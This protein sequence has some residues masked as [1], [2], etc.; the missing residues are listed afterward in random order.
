MLIVDA[1][2]YC[3]DARSMESLRILDE[4]RAQI[5]TFCATLFTIPGRC[6]VAFIEWV[7]ETRTWL[8]LVPHGWHHN[9]NYECLIW[10]MHQCSEALKESRNRGLTT[11]GFKAPGW[12]ISDACYEALVR[13]GY[14][15]A[16]QGCN[17][18]RRPQGL[19]AYVIDSDNKAAMRVLGPM[20]LFNFPLPVDPN[21]TK[22]AADAMHF[23]IGH[24]GGRNENALELQYDSIIE[25][26]RKDSDFRFINEVMV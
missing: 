12:Q 20:G 3:E 17:D 22:M 9:S 14:W 21:S 1:D 5:P 11:R 26:A 2:D 8:D 13:E 4:L 7:K 10:T 25:A 16:D 24:L 18:H 6:S 19:K 23:H 15:C